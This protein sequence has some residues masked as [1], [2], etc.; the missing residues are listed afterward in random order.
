[1]STPPPATLGRLD[2]AQ[3]VALLDLGAEQDWLDYKES[4]DLSS[5]RGLSEIVK[6]I[7]AMS[8]MGG[9]LVVGAK[10]DG[11]PAGTALLRPA[12][13]DTSV[14][15]AKVRK[16]IVGARVTVARHAIGSQE[17]ALVCV[18]P[19]PDGFAIFESDGTHDKPNGKGT[20]F[21]FRKGEVFARHDTRSERWRQSDVALIRDRL[22]QERD[23]WERA[24][25]RA[26][27]VAGRL[28]E[29]LQLAGATYLVVSLAATASGD[30]PGGQA[31]V[32]LA[33]ETADLASSRAFSTA[34][35]DDQDWLRP[36]YPGIA[37]GR[38]VL[39]S[40]QDVDRLGAAWRAELWPDGSG[41][42]AV[43]VGA[44]DGAATDPRSTVLQDILEV[45]LANQ[46]DL[47]LLWLART[48]G[49]GQVRLA[50]RLH[51]AHDDDGSGPIPLLLIRDRGRDGASAGRPWQPG[52]TD[53]PAVA[54]ASFED[55][56]GEPHGPL[57]LAHVLVRELLNAFGLT[58][59]MLV[60]DGVLDPSHAFIPGPRR[61]LQERAKE[62]QVLPAGY[63]WF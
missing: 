4:V 29:A 17:Y 38:A 42:C 40:D 20:E 53:V 22:R 44:R 6:D 25:A 37:A 32:D 55:A 50:A 59:P 54:H 41:A 13:L 21:V 15:G 61:R 51:P 3:L 11:T 47:L 45:E 16:Y 33:V 27:E 63:R 56:V 60:Q 19:H 35:S 8:M 2:A 18:Q 23:A 30:A 28:R 58:E 12:D 14:L 43:R 52:Q 1:M 48:G 5:A 39:S 49:G 46:V 62:R 7:G 57:R 31:L 9:Y 36:E 24:S 26:H 34:M 10:D